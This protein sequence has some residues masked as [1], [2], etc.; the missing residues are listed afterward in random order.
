MPIESTEPRDQIDE[1][2]RQR[3]NALRLF[4]ERRPIPEPHA[5][6][7]KHE[8]PPSVLLLAVVSL[9][10]VALV[11]SLALRTRG[12]H[13]AI[14]VTGS[15]ATTGSGP[16]EG[17][18]RVAA[19]PVPNLRSSFETRAFE[20]SL[21]D[22]QL[23]DQLLITHN[24]VWVDGVSDPTSDSHCA[25][26]FRLDPV[27]LAV[28]A[29]T[30]LPNVADITADSSG[31]WV[32]QKALTYIDGADRDAF[33]LDQLDP[34]T[35][36]LLQQIP[37]PLNEVHSSDAH[38]QITTSNGSIWLTVPNRK[39]VVRISGA[40]VVA[41][42]SVPDRPT[43]IAAGSN[44]VWI[45]SETDTAAGTV[46]VINPA[47]NSI[48]ARIQVGLG[49]GPPAQIAATDTAVLVS[50]SSLYSIDANSNRV[51]DTNPRFA[52]SLTASD[53]ATIWAAGPLSQLPD[54]TGQDASVSRFA[55]GSAEPD[56]AAR[57][58]LDPETDDIIALGAGDGYLWGIDQRTSSTGA[59]STHLIR[60]DLP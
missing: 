3:L 47:D 60:L 6:G 26:I 14:T 17:C 28:T 29:S 38:P 9:F 27:T 19:T 18:S 59:A 41:E 43:A 2:L 46:I 53:S 51:D 10:A 16:P 58:A 15:S 4:V 42:I 39:E 30:C 50:Q 35:G 36:R 31:V 55:P 40:A 48:D 45:A 24:A 20:C 52:S 21:P 56:A 7:K 22:V 32:L 8:R 33:E 5:L 54:A 37:L 49:E 1:E 34:K 57:L 11:A 13:S 44:H 12:S 23:G 25:G